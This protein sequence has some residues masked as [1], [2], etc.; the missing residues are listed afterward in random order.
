MPN[1]QGVFLYFLPGWVTSDVE[2]AARKATRANLQTSPLAA[3]LSDCLRTE[4]TFQKSLVVH[5]V[6]KG[7]SGSSGVLIAA[8]PPQWND[9][10]RIGFYA[11]E[12][13]WRECGEFWLGYVT[14]CKPGPDSLQ[15]EELV[16][17]YDYEMHD[18]NIW[19]APMIRY[20]AGG[21]NLPKTMGVDGR[22]EF[23]EA[24]VD[25]MKWA[26][27]LSCVIWDQWFLGDGVP[28]KDVFDF[29]VK[30]LSVNYRIGPQEATA[31]GLMTNATAALVLKAAIAEPLIQEYIAEQDSKKNQPTA[32]A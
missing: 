4:R 18:E 22:G 32:A 6:A 7:P 20:P 30:C 15:R 26:W 3:A 16:S 8:L 24:V 12:Q 23:I 10:H 5:S 25:A 29:A 28:K 9:V 1:A 17:G 14:S 11:E 21:A 27:D 19:H 31:L 13:T 2:G